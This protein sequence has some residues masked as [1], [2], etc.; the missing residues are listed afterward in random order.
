MIRIVRWRRGGTGQKGQGME[1]YRIARARRAFLSIVAAALAAGLPLAAQTVEPATIA[2]GNGLTNIGDT[3]EIPITLTSGGPQPATLVL[4]I[5]YNPAKVAPFT[6]FYEFVLTDL[7]GPVVDEHGNAVTATSAV[8]PEPAVQ[9]AGKLVDTEVHPEGV[10]AIAITGLNT[11]TMPDG[12]L[13]TAAFEVLSG[14]QEN[15][16]LDLIGAGE[17]DPAP[18]DEED[19]F[20][21]AAQANAQLLPLVI[22]DGSIQVGCTPPPA[23]TDVAATQGSPDAVVITWTGI[24]LANA[25]YRVFRSTTPVAGNALPLGT[26][27]QTSTS[28]QD[29]TAQVPVV[30]DPGGCFREPDITEVHYYYWVKARNE[31][32]CESELSASYA[33]GYRGLAKSASAAANVLAPGDAALWTVLLA[34]LLAAGRRKARRS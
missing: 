4:F 18:V 34:I 26:A 3:V 21:S 31:I 32:G 24:G 7:E 25:E 30:N 8:R 20:S 22:T 1:P 5:A 11:T 33:E 15:E 17:D 29:V 10:L 9:N 14:A 23:P 19:V 28:F 13:L 6:D 27:W 12:L 2:I 16:Q